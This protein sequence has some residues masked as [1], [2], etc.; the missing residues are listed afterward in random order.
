MAEERQ[1]VVETVQLS[2]VFRDFW[3]RPKAKALDRVEIQV[4]RGEIFG[5]LGPNGSGKSTLIKIL[6][7][8]LFP[9]SGR[10]AIFGRD[11]RNLVIK[12]R[13]GY[14]PE[15]SYLYRYLNAEET[16]MF[17]GRLFNLPKAECR[18]RVEL[19]LEMVGLTNQKRRPIVEYSK[20]MA[21]R[22]GLAQA[23]INDPDLVFLDEPTTGLD[24]IGTREIKD[25]I[26]ELRKQGKTVVLCSHLLSDVEDVCD[27]VAVLYGG[28]VRR[29]G[30]MEDLLRVRAKTQITSAELKRETIA[31]VVDMIT[32]M[33]GTD[34]D[35]QVEAPRDRLENFFLRVVE[36]ARAARLETAGVTMGTTAATFFS[37]IERGE[38][39]EVILQELLKSPGVTKTV[40]EKTV[41]EAETPVVV[42]ASQ[43]RPRED[44]DL[45]RSLVGAGETARKGGAEAS[46]VRDVPVVL[47]AGDE[48]VKQATTREV[49]DSLIG[50]KKNSADGAD[51]PDSE[52]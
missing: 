51:K 30:R 32:K 35:I 13:I 8:L 21:R 1:V 25:L 47:P 6:L 43:D 23:L 24:P 22:I 33:E 4:F 10:A 20:G 39:A 52:R 27:R 34:K 16:L 5:L 45:L 44:K 19:L 49:L 12:D 15:E 14:M 46:V 50:K 37:G 42:P 41:E 29:L 38:K 31:A 48:P 36:E 2:K 18:H 3:M 9:T 11:P 17:Y 28:R 40:E 7:G 26:L